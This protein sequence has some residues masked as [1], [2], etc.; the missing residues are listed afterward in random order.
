M[1][2]AFGLCVFTATLVLSVVSAMTDP[3]ISWW[4]VAAVPVAAGVGSWLIL[5][6][7]EGHAA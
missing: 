7:G 6:L 5:W 2:K 3:T 1:S 4:L